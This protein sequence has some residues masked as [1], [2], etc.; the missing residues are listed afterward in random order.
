MATKSIKFLELHY[1][2]TQFLIILN[3][4][5]AKLNLFVDG[6]TVQG[7]GERV[8]LFSAR[9]KC[10]FFSV[11]LLSCHPNFSCALLRS[12]SGNGPL[13]FDRHTPM[14]N[15]LITGNYISAKGIFCREDS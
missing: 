6:C 9:V 1:T 10:K 2:M 4:H 13:K 5:T 7:S 14:W 12:F 15:V 8:I 3:R 11:L